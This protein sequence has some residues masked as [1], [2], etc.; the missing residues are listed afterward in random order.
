VEVTVFAVD[1]DDEAAAA[2]AVV[3]VDVIGGGTGDDDDATA[4]S[5]AAA[6]DDPLS[7]RRDVDP[8]AVRLVVVLLL[9]E[10]APLM[11][12]ESMHA[13]LQLVFNETGSDAAE[14]AVL[15]ISGAAIPFRVMILACC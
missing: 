5:G 4:A 12:N 3:D 8:A 14:A 2:A 11:R 13:G 10:D 9:D 15:L 1:V 6:F 7:H